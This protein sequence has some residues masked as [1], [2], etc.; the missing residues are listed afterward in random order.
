ML[1]HETTFMLSTPTIIDFSLIAQAQHNDPELTSLRASSSLHLQDFPLPFPSD[2]TFCDVTTSTPHPYIPSSF[3]PTVF[4]SLHN[5]SH[6]GI[7]ATQKLL[8]ERFVWPGINKDAHQWTCSCTHCQK[9]KVTCD[10]AAPIGTFTTPDARFDHIHL[11]L[12]CPLPISACFHYLLTY[13][14]RFTWWAD[15]IPLP[16]IMAETV[17]RASVSGWISVFG[18]PS[19]IT[20]D[21]GA[22]F[23]A[24]LFTLLSNLLGSN[25]IH[26][27]AYHP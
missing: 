17:A 10:T 9:A 16:D 3:R 24:S 5:L 8:T 4:A 25:R 15:A 19:T 14:D 2:T 11:D 12:V 6:P 23:K 18:A 26:T 21:R 22:Q 7:R 27:T 1:S 13:I 20:T